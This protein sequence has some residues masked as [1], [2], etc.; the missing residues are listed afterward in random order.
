[1]ITQESSHPVAVN[2]VWIKE[3][4]RITSARSYHPTL[5]VANQIRELRD[6][7]LRMI[8]GAIDEDWWQVTPPRLERRQ[9]SVYTAALPRGLALVVDCGCLVGTTQPC[10]EGGIAG[11]NSFEP[12]Y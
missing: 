8:P 3:Y 4:R 9:A 10:L 1:M 5:F 11:D 6:D 2:P 7:N 12:G